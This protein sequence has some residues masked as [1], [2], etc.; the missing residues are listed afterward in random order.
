[1]PNNSCKIFCYSVIASITGVNRT[2]F[3]QRFEKCSQRHRS[4]SRAYGTIW[5]RPLWISAVAHCSN[6]FFDHR[7]EQRANES[8][9]GW[10]GQDFELNQFGEAQIFMS[11]KTQTHSRV[12]EWY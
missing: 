12:A 7:K 8:K 1:M 2:D 3:K 11:I 5:S 10:A 4:K 9:E 6:E